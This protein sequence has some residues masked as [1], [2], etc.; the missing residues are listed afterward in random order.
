MYNIDVRA[1][2]IWKVANKIRILVTLVIYFSYTS[3]TP[4]SM[5]TTSI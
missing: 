4:K 2:N 3:E 5:K 1:K